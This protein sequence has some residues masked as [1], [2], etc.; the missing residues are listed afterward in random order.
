MSFLLFDYNGSAMKNTVY[1]FRPRIVVFQEPD[2]SS[3]KAKSSRTSN[4]NTVYYKN[5]QSS[6]SE[7]VNTKLFLTFLLIS[8]DSEKIKPFSQTLTKALIRRTCK[9]SEKINNPYLSCSS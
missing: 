6:F 2:L 8:T 9:I 1:S 7:G 4:S 5:E 3:E